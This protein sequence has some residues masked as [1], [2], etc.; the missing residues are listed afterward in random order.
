MGEMPKQKLELENIE[1]GALM[2]AANAALD[3]LVADIIARPLEQGP[4]ELTIKVKLNSLVRDLPD[5]RVQQ[6]PIDWSVGKKAPG[7]KGM[8]TRAF[9]QGKQA[10]INTG[11][12]MGE[13]HPDQMSFDDV[14]ES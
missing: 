8:T 13:G 6:A 7:M 12:P 10:I 5:R 1:C 11:D 3:E 9:I 14:G 4:R 2:D